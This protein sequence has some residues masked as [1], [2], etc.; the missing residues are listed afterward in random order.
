MANSSE[1]VPW[2]EAEQSGLAR[3]EPTKEL[4]QQ[5]YDAVINRQQPPEIG[6]PEIVARLIQER[7]R[8][9]SF[10]DSMQVLESLPSWGESFG[11]KDLATAPVMVVRGFH[12]NPSAFEDEDGRKGVY[13]VVEL[14]DAETGEFTTVQ[15]G[16]GNVLVQLVK[17]WEEGRFPFLARYEIRPTAT[18]GRSTHWLRSAE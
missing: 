16:A 4:V 9:G 7:I 8:Q 12:L 13:A 3:I 5:A 10:D 2:E 1:V 17:A 15:T 14:A 6:D 18:P 11:S